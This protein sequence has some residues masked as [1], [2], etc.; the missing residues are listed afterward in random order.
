MTSKITLFLTLL[1]LG[2]TLASHLKKNTQQVDLLSKQGLDR[3]YNLSVSNFILTATCQFQKDK[4]GN[5][6]ENKNS[7]DIRTCTKDGF[8]GRVLGWPANMCK[9]GTSQ[10]FLCYNNNKSDPNNV[11]K[12]MNAVLGSGFSNG[13][14]YCL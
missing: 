1:L 12:K 10:N 3:C 6:Q 11:N 9:I 14:L 5:I 2:V 7:I 8:G 13:S 4:M